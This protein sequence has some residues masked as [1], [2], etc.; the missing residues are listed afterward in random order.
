MPEINCETPR[1]ARDYS[2]PARVSDRDQLI[3]RHLS[4]ARA[5]AVDVMSE[6]NSP[7][8]I[9]LTDLIGYG[10]LGLVEAAERFDSCRGVAFTTFAY[11]RIRGAIYD[12]LRRMGW[13]SRGEYRRV[14]FAAAAN[15]LRQAIV[16]DERPR[17]PGGLEEEIVTAQSM[18]DTLIPVYLLSLD[19]TEDLP[20]LADRS[21]LHSAL[22]E[23]QELKLVIR[24]LLAELSA[25]DQLLLE[26]I[27]YRNVSMVEV[28]A[29]IGASKSWV[30]RLHARAV[31]RLQAV[32]EKHGML[33]RRPASS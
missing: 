8:Q 11:Y 33:E 24:A 2:T 4:Y 32:M 16:D 14:R 26:N 23:E 15:S 28:A 13:L 25:D 19:S 5:L 7:S 1:Q 22:L 30:S 17:P 20:E 9:E 6:L 21:A 3:E 29:R 10:E 18:I 27:Y 12:G 31:S